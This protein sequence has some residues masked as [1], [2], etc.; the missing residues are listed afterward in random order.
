MKTRKFK[1]KI[2]VYHQIE[3]DAVSLADALEQAEELMLED[4]IKDVI[5]DVEENEDE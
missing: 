2:T 5:I 3:V 1:L 4:H